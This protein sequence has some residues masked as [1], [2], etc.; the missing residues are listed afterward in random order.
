MQREKAEKT[1]GVNAFKFITKAFV[2]PI[3]GMKEMI[4]KKRKTILKFLIFLQFLWFTFYWLSIEVKF[5]IY[6]Y[7]RLVFKPFDESDYATFSVIIHICNAI[8]LMIIVPVLSQ[9]LKVHDAM[10]IFI[11]LVTEVISFAVTPFVDELWQFYLI[12]AFGAMGYCKYSTVRSMLSKCIE[13]DEVGK[14]FSIL[15]VI[16]ALAPV[17]GN[18]LFRQLYDA[19]LDSFPGAIFHLAGAF[20]LTA[21]LGNLYLYFQRDEIKNGESEKEKIQTIA[22]HLET[23]KL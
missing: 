17:A 16:A 4:L 21:A 15:A 22:G 6:L 12:Q 20:C 8:C 3:V 14:T 23:S 11:I 1:S 19:T 7:M 18:P 13:P 5:M 9:K 2:T 10:L